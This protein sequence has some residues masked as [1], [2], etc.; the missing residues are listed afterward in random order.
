MNHSDEK[1]DLAHLR[2]LVDAATPGEWVVGP[3]AGHVCVG[4]PLRLV[5]GCNGYSSNMRDTTTENHANATYISAF[6]PPTTRALLD[7]VEEL[8]GALEDEAARLAKMECPTCRQKED[9]IREAT[10]HQ[11]CKRFAAAARRLRTALEGL[12][13]QT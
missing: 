12:E 9:G 7:L 13:S 11:S 1:L 6:S 5:A 10:R 3:Y 8:A 2:R 4:K